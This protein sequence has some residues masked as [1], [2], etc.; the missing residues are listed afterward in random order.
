MRKVFSLIICIVLILVTAC[1][2]PAPEA[3]TNPQPSQVSE[4]VPTSDDNGKIVEVLPAREQ[5]GDT[6]NAVVETP[7][8]SQLLNHTHEYGET[9][10]ITAME[11]KFSG[12]IFYPLG[13]LKSADKDIIE[14]ANA[15]MADA[16]KISD[17][18]SADSPGTEGDFS[19]NYDSYRVG[20]RYVSVLEAGELNHS[21]KDAPL[22]TAHTMNLDLQTGKVLTTDDLFPQQGRD[23]IFNAMR[24]KLADIDDT[25]IGQNDTID[26]RWLQYP[27][28]MSDGIQFVLPKGEYPA[29]KNGGISI[30]LQYSEIGGSMGI[31]LPS[32]QESTAQPTEEQQPTPKPTPSK[33]KKPKILE[34]GICIAHDVHVRKTAART[35]E[36]IGTLSYNDS[37]EVIEK[38]I[39][40][41]WYKIWFDGQEAYVSSEFISLALDP[42][43]G[44]GSLKTEK[45]SSAIDGLE[46]KKPSHSPKPTPEPTEAKKTSKPHDEGNGVEPDPKKKMVALTFDDGPSK[47]TPRLLDLLKESGGKA[48][49]CMVGNRVESFST[50]VQRVTKEGHQIASHTWDHKKLTVLS[51]EQIKA[52]LSK[53]AKEI[54]KYSGQKVKMLRP[55]Y[56]SVNDSEKSMCK[57]L[58]MYIVNWDIDTEDWK[59]HNADKT[60]DAIMNHVKSGDIILCHDLYPATA[61]AM[62]RVIPALVKKGFQLVTV[63]ELLS[64]SKNAPDPGTVHRYE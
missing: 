8:E 20:K 58:G 29:S 53:S 60:Y 25:L 31:P 55:P 24:A 5:T 26:E 34:T 12:T 63:E 51:S 2:A 15:T 48:T 49:F 59:T 10:A 41:S 18:F 1:S 42:E 22:E 57:S 52:E 27:L 13:E 33:T 46:T 11:D 47:V 17:S 39:A 38:D 43:S 54:E 50:I 32:A 16:K 3:A 40:E 36:L 62:E 44:I 7:E 56:G 61:D 4:D 35:G 30:Y 37:V 21:S 14:W 23:K 45:P 6:E 28:L 19:V 9:E 64:H